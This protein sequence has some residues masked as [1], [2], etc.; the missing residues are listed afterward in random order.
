MSN[1]SEKIMETLV[2]EVKEGAE[3]IAEVIEQKVEEAVESLE[4]SLPAP[5][6]EV[7]VELESLIGSSFQ[8]QCF[9]CKALRRFVAKETRRN[10]KSSTRTG[11]LIGLCTECGTKISKFHSIK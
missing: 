3:I 9:K 4:K 8:G 7:C 10:S 1:D 5:V 11:V 2:S 6:R